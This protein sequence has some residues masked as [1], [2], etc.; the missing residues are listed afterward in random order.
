MQYPYRVQ[1]L[2]EVEIRDGETKK[3]ELKD[4]EVLRKLSI[5]RSLR[6]LGLLHDLKSL[7]RILAPLKSEGL[8]VIIVGNEAKILPAE[9]L[10]Q[11]I[12]S[13]G[14]TLIGLI[15]S[16]TLQAVEGTVDRYEAYDVT[17]EHIVEDHS[18]VGWNLGDV[19][20]VEKKTYTGSLAAIVSKPR[21]LR[22]FEDLVKELKKVFTENEVTEPGIIR[23]K[24]TIFTRIAK[25]LPNLVEKHSGPVHFND[26]HTNKLLGEEIRLNLQPDTIDQFTEK[27][28]RAIGAAISYLS[29]L[30]GLREAC[31]EIGKIYEDCWTHKYFNKMRVMSSLS[32]SALNGS[33][34]NFAKLEKIMETLQI[35]YI[36]IRSDTA[37]HEIEALKDAVSNLCISDRFWEQAMTELDILRLGIESIGELADSTS[38]RVKEAALKTL[39]DL[40]E[41]IA[42]DANL[43]RILKAYAE[44][45][46]LVSLAETVKELKE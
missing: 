39:L 16:G 11:T 9:Q 46:Y 45:K 21:F 36:E 12:T 26:D 41:I 38:L 2:D 34:P 22:L 10:D 40:G 4:S 23:V 30:K 33:L 27:L 7:L 31:G 32:V 15:A 18:A 17:G 14:D 19:K 5:D 35:A 25:I 3:L 37:R 43:M 8:G 1:K 6:F 28:S 44:G 24:D 29:Q 42:E 13:L 20:V